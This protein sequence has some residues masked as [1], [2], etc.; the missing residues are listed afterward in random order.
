MSAIAPK[1]LA[2]LVWVDPER[3]GGIACFKGTRV[4]IE[5]LFDWLA[6]GETIDYFLEQ[7]PTVPPD[8]ARAVIQWSKWKACQEVGAL[9]TFA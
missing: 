1:E 3:M 7:F 8:Q 6:T 2:D 5:F 9:E 4:P